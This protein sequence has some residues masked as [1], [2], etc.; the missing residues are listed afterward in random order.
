MMLL[1]L[2]WFYLWFPVRRDPGTHPAA[3]PPTLA[4][5]ES[6]RSRSDHK[7]SH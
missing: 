4:D 5:L 7:S 6:K 3:S 2:F 1:N